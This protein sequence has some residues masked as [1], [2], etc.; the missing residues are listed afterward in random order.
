MSG[1]D[2]AQALS[3]AL[4]NVRRHRAKT[5]AGSAAFEDDDRQTHSPGRL[6][7]LLRLPAEYARCGD[8]PLLELEGGMLDPSGPWEPGVL[9]RFGQI[10]PKIFVCVD[11]Y[12]LAHV[13]RSR[14][15]G[16]LPA[17]IRRSPLA[18]GAPGAHPR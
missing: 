6:T 12:W 15:V 7:K 14:L 16:L 13:W 3:P 18:G 5:R 2:P 9:D 17:S 10:A 8:A 11:G 4:P 1:L